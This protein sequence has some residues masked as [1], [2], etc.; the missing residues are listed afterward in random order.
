MYAP[1]ALLRMTFLDIFPKA[2]KRLSTNPAVTARTV[3]D[4]VIR[5][6]INREGIHEIILRI[7][8]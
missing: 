1:H 4:I 6:P 7:V 8:A 3:K 2:I 5:A